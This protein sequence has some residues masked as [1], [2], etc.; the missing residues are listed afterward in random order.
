MIAPYAQVYVNNAFPV[1]VWKGESSVKLIDRTGDRRKLA[2]ECRARAGV[3][4]MRVEEIAL[5]GRRQCVSLQ[6]PVRR[7]AVLLRGTIA[8]NPI[9]KDG[10]HPKVH[11]VSGNAVG[12]SGAK[13]VCARI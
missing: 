11:K 1:D 5:G 4:D 7:H 8:M 9:R 10:H 3:A 12:L 2:V 6:R 13:S